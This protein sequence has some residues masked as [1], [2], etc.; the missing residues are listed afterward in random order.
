MALVI[1]GTA[2]AEVVDT[3]K[4]LQPIDPHLNQD[5]GYAVAISGTNAVVGAPE[6]ALQP[7][8]GYVYSKF[9]TNWIF[10]QKLVPVQA[11]TNSLAGISVSIDGDRLALGAPGFNTNLSNADPGVVYIY[12]QTNGVWGQQAQLFAPD[13]QRADKFGVSIALSGLS[14][15]IGSSFHNDLGETNNGS[16]Y[17]FDLT[18][19]GWQLSTKILPNDLTNSS[20]FGQRV[21]MSGNTLI[22][23]ASSSLV[24][25]GNFLLTSPGAAYVYTRTNVTPF[26]APWSL[27]QKLLPND[28]TDGGGFGYSVALDGDTALI[29][30]PF[31]TEGGAVFAFNRI[32][33]V[34]TQQTQIV[35][36]DLTNGDNFGFSIALQGTRAVIGA[37]GKNSNNIV[38]LGAAYVFAETNVFID[39][40]VFTTNNTVLVQTNTFTDTNA[41]APT[42]ALTPP[43]F[44][45]QSNL[46]IDSSVFA[47]N[48]VVA[49][50]N[51]L[52]LTNGV[53]T[54]NSGWTE[55]QELL[56][57]QTANNFEFG[58]SVGIG[59]QGILVGTPAAQIGRGTGAA[60]MFGSSESI[61][62]I[63]SATASPPAI[64]T[65]RNHLFVP[66]TINVVTTGSNVTCRIISV[67]SNQPDVGIGPNADA[68]DS[69][70]TGDLTV[71]L[72]AE[73]TDNVNVDR[74]YNILVACT[75]QFGN[76]VTTTVPVIVPHTL[77]TVTINTGSIFTNTALF[78]NVLLGP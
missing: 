63:V 38:G 32:G 1:V 39:T 6:S 18:D 76:V 53:G 4:L 45:A 25:V 10:Q 72:R 12:Q 51:E 2:K 59:A 9:G 21:A 24:T 60:Y 5:F 50:T 58:F 67:T 44:L 36:S 41:F 62:S 37:E 73:G 26:F 28:F 14:I 47:S 69:I 66:V 43:T 35:S 68:P 56:P 23:C 7:G 3:A 55:Q 16:I 54:T 15:V 22:A 77:G 19:A 42:N 8:V 57:L 64:L 27:Q 71:L 52:A 31:T 46:F 48:N 78:P 49:A 29:G 11:T 33:N 30:A 13:G 75:D 17:V 40:N 20:F 74:V 61:L 34:W 65:P 70:I